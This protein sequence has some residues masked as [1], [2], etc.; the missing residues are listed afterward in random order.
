MT[1]RSTTTDPRGGALLAD[2]HALGLTA[3]RAIDVADLVFVTGGGQ[4]TELEH[5]LVD[6]ML[7]TGDWSLPTGAAIETALLPGV[8][9]AA[10]QAVALAAETIGSPV[11]AV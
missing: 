4:R 7:Q 11:D 9:D 2:A 5:L 6:P 3:I 10:A 8:T 1:I